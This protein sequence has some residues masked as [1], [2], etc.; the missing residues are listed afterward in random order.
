MDAWSSKPGELHSVAACREYV[1]N[2]KRSELQP[3]NCKC[4]NFA[5]KMSNWLHYFVRIGRTFWAGRNCEKIKR[6]KECLCWR[7]LCHYFSKIMSVPLLTAIDEWA[8]RLDKTWKEG[9]PIL[10]TPNAIWIN[11]LKYHLNYASCD[12]PSK[13]YTK[14]EGNEKKNIRNKND[15]TWNW[16]VKKIPQNM[17]IIL[18]MFHKIY[19]LNVQL[20][21]LTGTHSHLIQYITPNGGPKSAYHVEP[22]SRNVFPNRHSI[23]KSERKKN[24]SDKRN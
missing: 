8:N 19:E 16:R 1:I 21:P 17:L 4:N 5:Q 10:C 6:E 18:W 23:M 24:I 12:S 13:F 22:N 14:T 11:E 7:L 3:F 15:A 2:Y 20:N 9:E